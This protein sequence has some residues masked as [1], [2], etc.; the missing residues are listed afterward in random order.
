MNVD[1]QLVQPS[2]PRSTSGEGPSD[3]AAD[4][5]LAASTLALVTQVKHRIVVDRLFL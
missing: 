1:F 4:L 3:A 5:V 2:T